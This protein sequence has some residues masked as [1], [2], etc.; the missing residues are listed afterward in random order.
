MLTS[1]RYTE[2]DTWAWLYNE[3]MGPQYYANQMPS[4]ETMLLSQIPQKAEILDLCCGTGHLMQPLI[5]RGYSVTGLDGSE[6]MLNYAR[7]NAPQAKF[8]LGDARTFNLQS[9]FDGI[10]STSAS[11]NHVLNLEEL[12]AVFQNVYQALKPSGLFLFDL[13]HADQMQ[14]WWKGQIAEGEIESNYAWY[15]VPNYDATI[16]LGNFKITLFQKNQLKTSTNWKSFY[17]TINSPLLTKLRL[18]LIA[19]VPQWQ[20][21][22][23]SEIIYQVKGYFPEEVKTALEE[24]GFTQVQIKTIEG[25]SNLDNNH[26]AYFI[27]NK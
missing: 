25:K 15:L 9:Q 1:D 19:K 18:R 21:W 10:Y 8:I 27:C 20:N 7:Q 11:L 26:S 14:K 4:L 16:R 17:N 2:Y 23:R 24:V 12:K 22:Q 5:Q 13:N 3:T 6:E